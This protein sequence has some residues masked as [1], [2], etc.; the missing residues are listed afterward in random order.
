LDVVEVVAVAKTLKV[1]P[2]M[3]ATPDDI[4]QAEG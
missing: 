4:E 3:V 1:D 2:A